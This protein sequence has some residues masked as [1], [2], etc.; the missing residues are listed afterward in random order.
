MSVLMGVTGFAAVPELQLRIMTYAQEAPTMAS[1][2]S[3]AA[4]NVGNA[5]G[6]MLSGL[7]IGAGLGFTSPQWTLQDGNAGSSGRSRRANPI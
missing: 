5:I 1:G 7:A 6:P 2:S 3:I 4:F